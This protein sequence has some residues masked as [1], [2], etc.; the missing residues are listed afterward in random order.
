MQ[1][2]TP[3]V[4]S[5]GLK[6]VRIS[7]LSGA[8]AAALGAPAMAQD[9]GK[10]EL[11]P[12]VHTV[13]EPDE[14]T[15]EYLVT[16]VK[17]ITITA[18]FNNVLIAPRFERQTTFRLQGFGVSNALTGV[19]LVLPAGKGPVNVLA[20][21]GTT[22]IVMD[23]TNLPEDDG[24]GGGSGNENPDEDLGD[25]SGF[26]RLSDESQGDYS[27]DQF[28]AG[29]ML[30]HAFANGGRAVL[31]TVGR[32][33]QD[34]LVIAG[35]L[36]VTSDVK[37]SFGA[38]GSEETDV[39]F[40]VGPSAGIVINKSWFLGLAEGYGAIRFGEGTRAVFE[41]GAVFIIT[42][43]MDDLREPDEFEADDEAQEGPV[44]E[45]LV[46]EAAEGSVVTGVEHLE[47][48]LTKD[49]QVCSMT[50][51]QTEG[52]WR[53]VEREWRY[54]GPL[55]EVVNALGVEAM[56]VDA[57]K[58]L[59]KEFLRRQS[60]SEFG[61]TI[62]WMTELMVG[63][64]TSTEM[65]RTAENVVE[66]TS[67]AAV[68]FEDDQAV[69]VS[70][71]T[72]SSRGRFKSVDGST[73][74]FAE[75]SR[76]V[77]GLDLEVHLRHLTR[78]GGLVVS[79]AD[80]DVGSSFDVFDVSQES[81]IASL[82]VYY[83]ES[84]DRFA[85]TGYGMFS[86]ANDKVRVISTGDMLTT[87]DPSRRAMTAGVAGSFYPDWGGYKDV[88]FTGAVS[89]TNYLKSTY[90]IAFDGERVMDVEEES[91]W[92]GTLQLQAGWHRLFRP[93][94]SSWIKADVTLG[95]RVRAG[96]LEV[97]Q[98]VSAGGTSSSV[99]HD[100]LT[101]G[102]IFGD[103]ALKVRLRDSVAGLHVGGSTGPDGSRSWTGG[104]SFD[105]QF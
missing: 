12:F 96:D 56:K 40:H 87:G 69:R 50:F 46:F 5:L 47:G 79:Y 21:G 33:P 43:G 77:T 35:H 62:N 42:D 90:G 52:G 34:V 78:F 68:A 80:A 36:N 60:P 86:G 64:G 10:I 98:T 31:E 49:G 74:G 39:N 59:R 32:N 85:V 23:T 104:V 102:E 48:F 3:I 19:S 28:K 105:Y 99:G 18:G 95:G 13:F 81:N 1:A 55:E 24:Q 22:T 83:G 54:E 72:G 97:R 63:A 45:R 94:S 51:E 89:L 14:E 57:P 58:A 71:R 76:D 101:R 15:R 44:D 2:S 9:T 100:D 37:M 66:L 67:R 16:G 30:A 93:A 4:S 61:K 75:W 65:I 91:R 11:D 41:K 82:A 103:A 26:I 27:D 84:S 70:A 38:D 73:G 8:V 53:V 7:L 25:L 17:P 29:A 6:A 88:N 92:V 20:S